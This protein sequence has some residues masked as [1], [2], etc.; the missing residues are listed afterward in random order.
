MPW[1]CLNCQK[2]NPDH[3]GA[4]TYCGAASPTPS[5]RVPHMLVDRYRIVSVLNSGGMGRVF[6]GW[7]MD[8]S[9]AVAIKEMLAG[10]DDP[11]KKDYSQ[12]KF[13]QEVNFLGN[14]RHRGLPGLVDFF[15]APQP[16]TGRIIHYLVMEFIDGYDLDRIMSNRAL[17]PLPVG[18]A[19]GYC[20]QI[21]E[22]LS[23]LHYQAPPVIFRDLKPSNV[24]IK[25][26]KVYLVDFGIA[27]EYIPGKGGTSIGTPGY[28]APEQYQ[29]ISEPRS[30]L[31]SLGVVMHFVLT[32]IDP[33]DPDG[34]TFSFEK[35][36]KINPLVPSGVEA[37]VES[38]LS[39]A[40]KDRPSSALDAIFQL[41][42]L[43]AIK[44]LFSMLNMQASGFWNK[45]K[46]SFITGKNRRTSL[47]GAGLQPV[48]GQSGV[49]KR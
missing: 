37:L 43:K 40:V 1:L 9:R 28:A 7:D 3:P 6:R 19:V 38:M 36:R 29:G 21:L 34:S 14:F 33:E 22:I 26:G 15:V 46:G 23:Y 18:E 24:I 12:K 47:S 2:I 31:Y 42:G 5:E 10:D 30:D 4:C 44:C 25:D 45:F 27:R 35:I 13:M 32:G 20:I 17:K 48:S 39:L 16:E 8:K 49:I 11:E 41:N